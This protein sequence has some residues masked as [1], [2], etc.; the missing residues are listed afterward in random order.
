MEGSVTLWMPDQ[1]KLEK[2]RHPYQRTYR[3]DKRARWET[4]DSYCDTYAMFEINFLY[5]GAL[6]PLVST[7]SESRI[8][9]IYDDMN[10]IICNIY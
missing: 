5:S 7:A 10:H 2:V 3:D 1:W 6:C 9:H 4:D 8:S